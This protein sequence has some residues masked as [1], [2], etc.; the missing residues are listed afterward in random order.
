MH[1]YINPLFIAVKI[2]LACYDRVLVVIELLGYI[3]LLLCNLLFIFQLSL[4]CIFPFT[5]SF[6][7]YSLSRHSFIR[8]YY[9]LLANISKNHAISYI[10]TNIITSILIL[11]FYFNINNIYDD[12]LILF[13]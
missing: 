3:L 7:Y 10:S 8:L 9:Y 4:Y 6:F 2:L 5:S 12:L 11:F 13:Y 1:K